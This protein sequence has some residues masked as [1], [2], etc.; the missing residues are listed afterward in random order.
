MSENQLPLVLSNE[1]LLEG[2]KV[3]DVDENNFIR[4]IKNKDNKGLEFV[5]DNYSNLILKVM[6]NF[7]TKNLKN[8]LAIWM[9]LK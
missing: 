7:K 9:I 5:V 1:K 8:I 3:L 4:K 2:G 6:K